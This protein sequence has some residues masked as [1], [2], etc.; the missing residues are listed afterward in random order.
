MI[1]LTHN[2]KRY[3]ENKKK[4]VMYVKKGFVII[5]NKKRCLNYIKKVEIIVILLE[6]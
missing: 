1:P 6:I 3:Y 2:E 5:K 4:N